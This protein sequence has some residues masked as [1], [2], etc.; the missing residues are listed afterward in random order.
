M[1][2]ESQFLF[3]S[4][5]IE[6]N[7]STA[8]VSAVFCELDKKSENG[9]VYRFSDANE[10]I[11]SL[12]GSVVYFGVDIFGRHLKN[13]VVGIVEEA[14]LVG[15]TIKGKI[16]ID[17]QSIIEKLKSGVKFLVSIGGTAYAKIRKGFMEMVNPI[18][19]HIAIWESSQRNIYG[20]KQSAGF[21]SAKIDKILEIEE[22]VL[23]CGSK[24]K[25]IALMTALEVL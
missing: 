8:L 6:F 11:E 14:V 21:S 5:T 10:I 3:V 2:S 4:K 12:I 24:E 15:K 25:L 22:S 20:E 23:F 18:V 16:R 19:N 1:S 13:K 9:R 17:S 7:E